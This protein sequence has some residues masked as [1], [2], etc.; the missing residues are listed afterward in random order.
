MVLGIGCDIIEIARIKKSLE[1]ENFL[2]RYF[3]NKEIKL[4]N[5]RGFC[6]SATA[7]GNF[8]AKEAV[9]KAFGIGFGDIMPIDIEILRSDK[10][11]PY[12]ILHGKAL[13]E[14]ERLEALNIFLSISHSKEMAIAYVVIEN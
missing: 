5:E 14:F 8:C 2:H 12:V 1:K 10:N 3:T 11:A 6:A 4:I 9:A 7:A 13:L